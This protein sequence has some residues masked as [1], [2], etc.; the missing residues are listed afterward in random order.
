MRSRFVVFSIPGYR[1]R[2]R[3]FYILD[4]AWNHREVVRFDPGG[5]YDAT[6]AAAYAHVECERLNRVY[7]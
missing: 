3:T 6:A 5:H 2:G 4:R 1:G 7:G